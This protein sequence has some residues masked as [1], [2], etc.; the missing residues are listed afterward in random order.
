MAFI[1]YMIQF[2]MEPKN[3]AIFIGNQIED[4]G[5]QMIRN[6]E[7]AMSDRAVDVAEGFSDRFIALVPEI[8]EAGREQITLLHTDL[9]PYI[10]DE[11]SFMVTEYIDMN[12]DELKA[13]A[14]ANSSEDFALYFTES[15]MEELTEQLDARMLQNYGKGLEYMDVNILDSLRSI[16]MTVSHLADAKPGELN[17]REQLQRKILARLVNSVVEAN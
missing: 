8:A 7:T 16:N 1:L 14:E 11:F 12:A 13:F 15:M 4:N 2:T 9:L 10:S 3:L 5:P 17:E 6:A